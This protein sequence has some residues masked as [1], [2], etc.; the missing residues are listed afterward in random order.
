MLRWLCCAGPQIYWTS[1]HRD[2]GIGKIKAGKIRG[3]LRKTYKMYF[4]LVQIHSHTN[5]Q[6][7]PRHARPEA[8]ARIC[9]SVALFATCREALA[10]F[11]V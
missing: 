2:I 1:I 8:A 4:L 7:A 5:I 6:S 10:Y 11:S 3:D 9:A